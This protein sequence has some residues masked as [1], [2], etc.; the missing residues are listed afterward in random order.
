MERA[1]SE[2]AIKHYQY[3]LGGYYMNCLKASGLFDMDKPLKEFNK[4]ELDRLL[5][6]EPIKLRTDTQTLRWKA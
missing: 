1:P 3:A 4:E 6:M 2:G 5:Y